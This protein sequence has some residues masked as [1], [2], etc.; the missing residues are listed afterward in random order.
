MLRQE[1]ESKKCADEGKKSRCRDYV[2]IGD[3][4]KEL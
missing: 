1:E 4:A 3:P 2:I